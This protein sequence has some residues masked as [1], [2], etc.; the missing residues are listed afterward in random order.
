MD[1]VSS[2]S[3]VLVIAATNRPNSI[4]P[5]LRRPGRFDKEIN[6]GIPDE[7]AR[8]EILQVHTKRMKMADDVQ[9]QKVKLNRAIAFNHACQIARDC[10]G[11]VGAD[12]AALCCEAAFHQI[13]EVAHRL[14]AEYKSS[15]ESRSRLTKV[16]MKNFEV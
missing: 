5:A 12:L 16:T 4:D 7:E 14:T 13:R 10:H 9:L 1:G 8:L 3:N 6:I 11:Y 15:P 2:T